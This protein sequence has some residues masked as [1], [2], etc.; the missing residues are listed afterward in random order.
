M[1]LCHTGLLTAGEQQASIVCVP[2]CFQFLR[3]NTTEK[4]ITAVLPIRDKAYNE[5]Q[6]AMSPKTR[7]N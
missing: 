4:S 6:G 2:P 5:L 3:R 1:V 7:S